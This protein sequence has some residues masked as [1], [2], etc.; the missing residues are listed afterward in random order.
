MRYVGI[1]LHSIAFYSCNQ[2]FTMEKSEK[3]VRKTT[4][5]LSGLFDTLCIQQRILDLQ[6]GSAVLWTR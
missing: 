2:D 5:K 4:P 3:H 6:L 1:V